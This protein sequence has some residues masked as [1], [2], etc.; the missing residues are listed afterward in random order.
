MDITVHKLKRTN[1]VRTMTEADYYA[2][3]DDIKAE[4]IDGVIYYMASPRVVHQTILLQLASRID[5]HI[6]KN[7]G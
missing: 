1:E 5:E 2:I 6:R 4:L 7:N 3:P